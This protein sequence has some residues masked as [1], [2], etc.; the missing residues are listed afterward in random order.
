M[1]GE[2]EPSHRMMM[3]AGRVVRDELSEG[4]REID[5]ELPGQDPA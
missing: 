4:T 3:R 1:S 5:V 2:N